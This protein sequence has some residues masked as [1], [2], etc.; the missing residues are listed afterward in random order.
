LAFEM[1]TTTVSA[2][3]RTTF[4]PGFGGALEKALRKEPRFGTGLI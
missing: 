1:I 4:I 2:F 3:A